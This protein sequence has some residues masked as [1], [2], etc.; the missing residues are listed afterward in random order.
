MVTLNRPRTLNW[1]VRAAVIG[2]PTASAA[3]A[4]MRYCTVPSFGQPAPLGVK[5]SCVDA[6]FQVNKPE[7]F[8]GA[9]NWNAASA[10]TRSIASEKTTVMAW[11]GSLLLVRSAGT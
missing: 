5:V 6:V 11:F 1:K 9:R 7:G 10:L 3:V 2:L 8:V 4:L